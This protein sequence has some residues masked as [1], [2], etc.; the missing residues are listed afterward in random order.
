MSDEQKRALDQLVD[1]VADKFAVKVNPA[2]REMISNALREVVA[3]AQQPRIPGAPVPPSLP[4]GVAQPTLYTVQRADGR[5]YVTS[6]PQLLAEIADHL[7]VLAH[8]ST[9]SM[10]GEEAENSGGRGRRRRGDGS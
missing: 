5:A 3:V 2:F 7:K 10:Y 9:V 6:V 1:M 4:G 8:L